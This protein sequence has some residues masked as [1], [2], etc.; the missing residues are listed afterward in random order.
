MSVFPRQDTDSFKISMQ[1]HDRD[2]YNTFTTTGEEAKSED[3]GSRPPS[4]P[5][6]LKRNQW[7]QAR[8]HLQPLSS[9]TIQKR[10]HERDHH[11]PHLKTK[12]LSQV[13]KLRPF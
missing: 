10:F 6:S 13:Q 4:A 9:P 5:L 1:Q 2:A 8:N 7:D 12:M 11:P 3:S